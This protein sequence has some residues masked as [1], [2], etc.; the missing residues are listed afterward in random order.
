MFHDDQFPL[1]SV[2]GSDGRHCLGGKK[3]KLIL[4]SYIVL[5]PVEKRAERKMGGEDG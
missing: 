4:A 3:K 2:V 5:T 1:M